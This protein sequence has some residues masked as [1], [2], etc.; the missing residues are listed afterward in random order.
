MGTQKLLSTQSNMSL[1]YI[2]AVVTLASC[3]FL[4]P[5]AALG[6]GAA[7]GLA[8]ILPA[9][10]RR[11][12]IPLI[13][14]ATTAALLLMLA[15]AFVADGSFPRSL[16]PLA[17]EA[18]VLVFSFLLIAL[19]R[20]LALRLS[21]GQE[22]VRRSRL[23]QAL[24]ASAVS[25]RIAVIIGIVH[26]AVVGLWTAVAG[27]PQGAAQTVWIQAAPPSVFLL[28]MLANQA[29]IASFNRMASR[30]AFVPVVDGK[31][32]MKGVEFM[33]EAVRP[34]N[35]HIHPVVRVAVASQGMWYLMPRRNPFFGERGMVDLPMEDFVRCGE[36]AV[37][38]A[39]RLV[40]AAFPEADVRCLRFNLH[41]CQEGS[42]RFVSLFTLDL[43]SDDRPLRAASPEGGK[44][45]TNRQMEANLGKRFFS[46][47]LEY[48]YGNLK[49]IIGTTE[50]YREL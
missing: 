16:V 40:Q 39:E 12:G 28:A 49:E 34:G 47:Y 7:A 2:P 46:S 43:G 37:R 20:R 5:P 19:V 32:E 41:Y 9:L 29:A 45:W 33:E 38:C 48:E 1:G 24:D 23:A 27:F 15:V 42:N 36:N 14:Y 13:L 30:L 26:L 10:L 3:A 44:L 22:D 17:V 21:A 11:R 25:A 6:L 50:K 31:G 35:P 18:G 8:G 4:A